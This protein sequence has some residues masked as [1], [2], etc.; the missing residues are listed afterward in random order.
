MLQSPKGGKIAKEKRRYKHNNLNSN[1]LWKS[2]KIRVFAT[3]F[4]V[5]CFHAS[6]ERLF[7]KYFLNLLSFHR[8]FHQY[9]IHDIAGAVF[10]VQAT[11][12]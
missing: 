5:G 7:V 9:Y 1:E 11:I 12:K 3:N 2:L 4:A 10:D 6:Y 8:A